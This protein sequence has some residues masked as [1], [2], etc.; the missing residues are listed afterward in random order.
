MCFEVAALEGGGREGEGTI[1]L[2]IE[3][4]QSS[5]REKSKQNTLKEKHG[6]EKA[7]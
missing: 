1:M 2:K 4:E 7:N 3:E 6:K 5:E